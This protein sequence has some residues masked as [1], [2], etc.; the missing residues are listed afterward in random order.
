MSTITFVRHA[1]A[2]FFSEDYD[3]LSAHGEQ[4]AK[5]LGE[6]W[7]FHNTD[8]SEVIVG[9]CRR[10]RQTA[11]IA[12]GASGQSATDIVELREFDEHQVDQFVLQHKESLVEEFPELQS[13]VDALEKATEPHVQARDFQRLFEAVSWRW[14]AG[15]VVRPKI[16]S[17]LDFHDRVNRGISQILT[18]TKDSPRRGRHIAVFSSVGPITIAFQRAT[19][20]SDDAAL[21]TGWRLRNCSITQALFSVDRLTLDSFNTLSHLPD[22][23][24]WSY[25]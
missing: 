15:D 4:Q 22:R 6:F 1:Q 21:S 2:S 25:R 18:G 17:W 11:E 9:S 20:C 24:D 8:L 12:L 10:H 23:N 13:L 16:E 5:H 14:L 3:Q 19:G 7:K